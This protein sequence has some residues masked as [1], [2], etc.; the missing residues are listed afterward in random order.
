RYSAALSRGAPPERDFS[1]SVASAGAGP[2]A[3]DGHH[4]ISD[5]GPSVNR[6]TVATRGVCPS[7]RT[8][9]GWSAQA[10]M[11]SIMK[12]GRNTEVR[13]TA[14]SEVVNERELSTEELD[15]ASGGTTYSFFGLKFTTGDVADAVAGGAKWLWD[16]I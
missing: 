7:S 11:E 15:A 4:T 1:M 9:H 8:S 12:T 3:C 13:E 14:K 10:W 5:L 16:H 6:F 2:R